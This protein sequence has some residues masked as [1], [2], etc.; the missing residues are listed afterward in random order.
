MNPNSFLKQLAGG[1]AF[2][3]APLWATAML[4]TNN[5]GLSDVWVAAHFGH[6]TVPLDPQGDPDGDGFS[7]LQECLCGTDPGHA[8][9]SPSWTQDPHCFYD[10]AHKT[11]HWYL[12]WYGVKGIRYRI[13]V[14]EDYSGVGGPNLGWQTLPTAYLGNNQVRS[15]TLSSCNPFYV[16][17]RLQCEHSDAFAADG[18]TDY[19]NHLLGTNPWLVDTSGNGVSDLMAFQ[20]GID[21]LATQIPNHDFGSNNASSNLLAASFGSGNTAAGIGSFAWGSRNSATGDFSTAFGRDT[22]ATGF[23]ALAGGRDSQAIGHHAT[24]LGIGTMA[25][26]YGSVVVGYF[27]QPQP[28]EVAQA[29]PVQVGEGSENVVFAVGVGTAPGSREN[30]ITVFQSGR[31]VIKPQGGFTFGP[32]TNE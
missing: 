6:P 18:L 2:L 12:A 15:A 22:V 9:S 28:D 16:A 13:E 27:N 8:A 1:A 29:I 11:E 4:D 19:E 20:Y 24:A 7:N 23:G 25:L 30:A 17:F 32:F 31:I 21:P 5:D 14:L 10:P 3:G 26:S